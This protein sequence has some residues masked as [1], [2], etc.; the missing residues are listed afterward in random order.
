MTDKRHV[1]LLLEK[2][3]S[4]DDQKQAAKEL[5]R[6]IK[7]IPSC[8]A[9]F[10][11]EFPDGITR[12]LDPLSLTKVDSDPDLQ[13]YLFATVLN[14][15]TDDKNK[16]LLVEHPVV[17]PLLTESMKSGTSETKR[18]AAATIFTLSTLN[19]N[20]FRIGNSGALEP[21]LKL[22]RVGHPLEMEEV[23]SAILSLC[24][25]LVNKVKFTEFGAVK[26]IIQ[27]MSDGILV[28]EVS[29]ILALLTQHQDAVDE[30]ENPKIFVPFVQSRK[31]CTSKLAKR[32]C[33]TIFSPTALLSHR[34]IFVLKLY[35]GFLDESMVVP[36]KL[37]LNGAG[38]THH[39]TGTFSTITSKQAYTGSGKVHLGD[40][41]T[42]A[43]THIGRNVFQASSRDL[44]LDQMLY[45]PKINKNLLSVSKFT[46]DN[47]VYFKFHANVCYVEDESK[48]V[49]LME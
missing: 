19:S 12:L 32:N 34:S 6:P 21:L 8:R 10:F 15:S 33:A 45:V 22:L 48:G 43:I 25:V 2:L 40:G 16:A 39:V 26:Q 31:H 28:D 23:S 46:Q 41:S 7:T 11:S 20:K 17:I 38:A 36:V 13:E 42:I 35:R 27:K 37:I 49:V 3:F 5:Q 44:L 14:I 47:S 24:E 18:N 30:F 4:L 9:I 29:S 1:K